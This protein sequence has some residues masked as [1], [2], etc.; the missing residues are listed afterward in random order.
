M[1]ERGRQRDEKVVEEKVIQLMTTLVSLPEDASQFIMC[2][3]IIISNLSDCS[4]ITSY[5]LR[6]PRHM[7]LYFGFHP[8]PQPLWRNKLVHHFIEQIISKHHFKGVY[9]WCWI[10]K[11]NHDLYNSQVIGKF[12]FWAKNSPFCGLKL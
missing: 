8:Y 2:W 3:N 7:V 11:N 10:M 4:F 12:G 9:R 6:P 5:Y 1:E